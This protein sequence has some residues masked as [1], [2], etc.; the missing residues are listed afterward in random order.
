MTVLTALKPEPDIKLVECL[1]SLL[2]EAKLGR[3]RHCVVVSIDGPNPTVLTGPVYGVE[4]HILI[5]G[6]LHAIDAL[7]E[8]LWK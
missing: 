8:R 6:C 5:S 2:D 7:K 4:A 1:E 3:L